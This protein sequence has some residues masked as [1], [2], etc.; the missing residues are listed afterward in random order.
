MSEWVGGWV[1]GWV[2]ARYVISAWV[3]VMCGWVL[4]VGGC[5]V[6]GCC[7]GGCCVSRWRHVFRSEWIDATG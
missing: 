7:V 5:C 4:C 6:G 1:G 3:G 2:G